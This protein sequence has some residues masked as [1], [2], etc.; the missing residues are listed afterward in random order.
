MYFY[1]LVILLAAAAIFFFVL[2]ILA[3][4]SSKMPVKDAKKKAAMGATTAGALSLGFTAA[5]AYY[6]YWERN[7]NVARY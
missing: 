2:M 7:N 5:L 1:P 3:A 6:I 4:R